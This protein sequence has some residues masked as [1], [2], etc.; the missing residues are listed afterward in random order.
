MEQMLFF[1]G[2]SHKNAGWMIIKVAAFSISIDMLTG[3]E[4]TAMCNEFYLLIDGLKRSFS[5]ITVNGRLFEDEIGKQL[6]LITRWQTKQFSR[7][8]MSSGLI[9]GA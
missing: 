5:M 6:K 9:S 7:H 2:K 1:H 8:L 4:I 3:P